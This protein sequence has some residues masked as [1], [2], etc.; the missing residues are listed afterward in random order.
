LV[1]RMS[2]KQ[3]WS[4][5]LAMA[6]ALLFSQCNVAWRS[7]LWARGSGCQSFDSP[8]YFISTKCGSNISARILTHR[9]HAVCFCTLVAIL[10]QILSLYLTLHMHTR[11]K[12]PVD[13]TSHQY[14]C[15]GET[16]SELNMPKELRAII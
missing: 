1:C 4:W 3:I 16:L 10:I 12:T 6:A 8:W 11:S 7:F 9:G 15:T 5:W 13:L 2:P 14:I